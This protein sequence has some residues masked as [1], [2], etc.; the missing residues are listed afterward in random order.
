MGLNS[1]KSAGI[2]KMKV[3]VDE[4]FPSEWLEHLAVNAK[5]Q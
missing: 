3:R 1:R 2:E 5:V 4:I